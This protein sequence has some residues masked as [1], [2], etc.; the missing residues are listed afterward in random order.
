MLDQ[1]RYLTLFENLE[2]HIFGP[3]LW[4]P[5][6]TFSHKVISPLEMG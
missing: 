6:N 4:L 1:M 2:I 3:V 5:K